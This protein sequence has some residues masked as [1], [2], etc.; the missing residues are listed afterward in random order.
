[1]DFGEAGFSEFFE[2]LFGPRVTSFKTRGAD[3]E[4]MLELSLEEAAAG[5]SLR[6]SLEDG[7]GFTVSLPAGVR[8]G[9]RVRVAGKGGEGA[10]GGPAGDLYLRVR[11]RP[12]S[13]FRLEDGH[14]Q[15]DV[16]VTPWEAALGATIEVPT[17]TGSSQVRLPAGSSSGRR[18]RVRGRGWPDRHGGHGDLY[19]RVRITVPKH[20]SERERELF[21]ALA[22]ASS[23]D[24]RG[25]GR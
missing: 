21:E 2:S 19:A 23:F 22:D 6:V 15:V 25:S 3:H 11:L 12:H 18:L 1:V 9:Q 10:G 14:L 16:P 4:V 5:G 7:G 8:D 20:L 24:P 13:R 17:L